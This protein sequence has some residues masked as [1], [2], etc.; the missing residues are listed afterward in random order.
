[1][2]TLG[3]NQVLSQFQAPWVDS[4]FKLLAVPIVLALVT[5]FLNLLVKARE[6]RIAKREKEKQEEIAAAEREKEEKQ[7]RLQRED[8]IRTETWKQ[9]LPVSHTYALKF[10]LPLSSAAEKL[11]EALEGTNPELSFFYVL[12]TGKRMTETRNEV[13]GF[14]FKDLRGEALAAICWKKQRELLLGQEYH[15][16]SLAVRAA[17]QLLSPTETYSSFQEKFLDNTAA[18]VPVYKVKE[19]QDSWEQFSGWLKTSGKTNEVVAYLK[20]FYAI[21]DY[22][23][24]RPYEY[25]YNPPARLQV[26]PE[27]EA[28]LQREGKEIPFTEAQMKEYFESALKIRNPV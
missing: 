19:I 14:Y 22:E 2:A 9:I 10:Y 15:P 25:W 18:P 6:N 4:L 3:D 11:A 5:L 8:T 28:L 24:N 26:E 1:V 13:G 17:I 20:G 27:I 7:Q 21:L 23:T 12:F 16:V